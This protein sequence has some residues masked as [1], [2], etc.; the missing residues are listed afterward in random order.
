MKRRKVNVIAD[1]YSGNQ[2]YEGAVLELPA[3]LYVQ[4]CMGQGHRS[5]A[6]G[7]GMAYGTL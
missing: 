3:T 7:E 2:E 5:A 1:S 4:E 6:C